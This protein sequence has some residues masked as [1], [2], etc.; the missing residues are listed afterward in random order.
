MSAENITVGIS[1][2]RN[3]A[4]AGTDEKN[5]AQ[6]GVV[7]ANASPVQ[8]IDVDF[9]IRGDAHFLDG[10]KH[11]RK[12]TGSEGLTDTV[13]FSS[14]V[15]GSVEIVCSIDG[16]EK[17]RREFDFSPNKFGN[18]GLKL[19][20]NSEVGTG[21]SI[22]ATATLNKDGSLQVGK[23]IT[24]DIQGKNGAYVV[25]NQGVKSWPATTGADGT[26]SMSLTSD[27]I[28]EGDIKVSLADEPVLYSKKSFKFVSPVKSYRLI[29]DDI[30]QGVLHFD[31]NKWDMELQVELGAG[32]EFDFRKDSPFAGLML[33]KLLARTPGTFGDTYEPPMFEAYEFIQMDD[34]KLHVFMS[35]KN[36]D[37]VIT[38]E[39]CY[40]PGFI[41]Y[42]EFDVAF[43]VPTK[44]VGNSFWDKVQFRTPGYDV[45]WSYG[46]SKDYPNRVIVTEV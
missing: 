2:V 43:G 31:L 18:L 30:F 22:G 26:A 9:E 4:M 29:C 37:F 42:A 3:N 33:N 5:E 23:N 19:T 27:E 25:G 14:V 32:A 34:R 11:V 1:A 13:Y 20:P 39:Q 28:G 8:N 21:F 16:Q 6:A 15:A 44:T 45:P 7:S 46:P 12:T 10:K 36:G 17:A 24:F 38:R 35:Q 40:L 41:N